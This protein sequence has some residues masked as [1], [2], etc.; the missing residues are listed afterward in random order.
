MIPALLLALAP[1][2]SLW[3]GVLKRYVL[4]DGRVR[5]AELH[6]GLE[7][8]GRF[9]DQIAAVSPDSHPS[10]FPSREDRLAYWLNAYNALVLHAFAKDYPARK[11]RLLGIAGRAWFF[12]R[13]K[14]TAGGRA[15]SLDDI[16]SNAVR[17]AFREPRIHF[18]LVCASA[19]CPWLRR[20]PYTGAALERQ[21]ED[22]ASRYLSQPRNVAV[23]VAERVVTVSKIFDWFR[24]DFGNDVV[25]FIARYRPE[26]REG[27]W[28]VRYFPYNWSLNDAAFST[29]RMSRSVFPP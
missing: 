11:D 21:L 6:A 3:D 23:Q 22:D 24:S 26:L 12:Y 14:F 4:E 19:S 1:D 7:P 18:A 16:E 8:L 17:A 29:A 2:L 28:R 5:Y 10:L 15:R 27:A 20:E 9:V 25:R 13:T